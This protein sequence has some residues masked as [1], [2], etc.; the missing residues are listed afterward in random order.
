MSESDDNQFDTIGMISNNSLSIMGD[1]FLLKFMAK[2]KEN[3]LLRYD[4]KKRGVLAVKP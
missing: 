3:N 4:W 2:D 1:I